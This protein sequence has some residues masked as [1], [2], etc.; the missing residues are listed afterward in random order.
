[1][2]VFFQGC[3]WV[4]VCV[5]ARVSLC[6]HMCTCVVVCVCAELP[7]SL[8]A[9]EHVVGMYASLLSLFQGKNQNEAVAVSV[10][11]DPAFG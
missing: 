2:S 11:S 4:V 1:M 7:A 8:P 10:T 3:A 5:H 6:L 9:L